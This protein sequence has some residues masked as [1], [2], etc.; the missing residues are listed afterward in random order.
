MKSCFEVVQERNLLIRTCCHNRKYEVPQGSSSVL[1]T[2]PCSPC[3]PTAEFKNLEQV[4]KLAVVVA[5]VLVVVVI[6][7]AIKNLPSASKIPILEYKAV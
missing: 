4:F 1:C 7:L 5:V 3:G 6:V 2:L